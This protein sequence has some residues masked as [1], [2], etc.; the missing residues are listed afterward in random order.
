MESLLITGLAIVLY[1]LGMYI[2]YKI[3]IVEIR[4]WRN[5]ELRCQNLKLRCAYVISEN[6]KKRA[7]E[8]ERLLLKKLNNRIKI[9]K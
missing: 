3:I 7:M 2:A 6:H 4:R 9:Q 5:Y 1:M 8:I